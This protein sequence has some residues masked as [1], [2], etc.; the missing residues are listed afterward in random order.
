MSPDGQNWVSEAEEARTPLYLLPSNNAPVLRVVMVMPARVPAWV[1]QLLSLGRA[2]GDV[3][4]LGM[5][6]EGISSPARETAPADM[7]ALFRYER[8]RRAGR[9]WQFQ[10][11]E[12]DCRDGVE[13]AS[14]FSRLHRLLEETAPDLILLLG[15]ADLA[16]R[17]AGTSRLGCWWL[18]SELLDE[19]AAAMALCRPILRGGLTTPIELELELELV[20]GPRE[21]RSLAK[22]RT[23]TCRTSVTGQCEHA[24]RKMPA[25]LLRALRGYAQGRG[26]LL[27][28]RTAR[29]GL[30]PNPPLRGMGATA[31]I[32]TMTE[33]ARLRWFRLWQP[34][35][36]QWFVVLREGGALLRPD[37]PDMPEAKVLRSAAEPGGPIWADPCAVV[38]D[39]RRLVFVEE[40]TLD[41]PKGHL[42]CLEVPIAGPARKLGIVLKKD[43]HLSFPLVFRW[44]AGWFMTVESGQARCVTLYRATDFPL[45]WEPVA[46]LLSG[47]ICVDP[48]LHFHD[49]GRW[50]LFV[51]VAEANGN[52][53]DDLFLFVSDSLLGPFTPHPA[54]PIVSDARSGRSAGKLFRHEGRLIRPA[55]DCAPSYGAAI[56]FNEIAELSPERYREHPLGQLDASWSKGLDGCHTYSACGP[57]EVVDI[58]GEAPDHLPSTVVESSAVIEPSTLMVSEPA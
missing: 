1:N 30:K 24:F 36:D 54:N 15:S 28:Q 2:G 23:A 39:G 6:V 56:V 31:L 21:S 13:V 47:W 55:Q 9:G 57:F 49:D 52:T 14:D 16:G 22:S 19:N 50:Y 4:L 5:V 38:E 18:G 43:H 20:D 42:A 37:L 32:R 51:T 53:W 27:R 29:M 58:R 7:R 34:Q 26:E 12:A 3:E 46:E 11:E 25:L 45:H 40:W 33:R 35:E 41:A 10:S 44:K 48:V 17:L 8:T